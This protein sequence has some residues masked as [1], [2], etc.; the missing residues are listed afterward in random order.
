M[1][2]IHVPGVQRAFERTDADG[3]SGAEEPIIGDKEASSI[4]VGWT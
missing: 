3:M 1:T 4:V 2:N